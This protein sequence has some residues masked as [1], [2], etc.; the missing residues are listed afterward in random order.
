MKQYALLFNKAGSSF[1]KKCNPLPNPL[2]TSFSRARFRGVMGV[3][4]QN[5]WGGVK[6]GECTKALPD[7]KRE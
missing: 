4:I 5:I 2:P 3:N 1:L 6:K 7:K